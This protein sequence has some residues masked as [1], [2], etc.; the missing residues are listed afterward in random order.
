MDL[1][2]KDDT[3]PLG[4]EKWGSGKELYENVYMLH[5]SQKNSCVSVSSGGNVS[6]LPREGEGENLHGEVSDVPNLWP[7]CLF[8]DT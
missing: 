8:Q 4:K 1:I 3:L 5:T 2:C 6:W 7:P